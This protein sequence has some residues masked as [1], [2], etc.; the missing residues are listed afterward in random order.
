MRRLVEADTQL[1]DSVVD[2][3]IARLRGQTGCQNVF[4]SFDGQ[5]GGRS[6]DL[7]SRLGLGYLIGARS[8]QP[9][10]TIGG[11]PEFVTGEDFHGFPVFYGGA[12]LMW[13]P[14]GRR[15]G[16]RLDVRENIVAGRQVTEKRFFSQA[17][18]S[19]WLSF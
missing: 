19:V 1:S 14:E 11:G 3:R 17:G 12:G 4:C 5:F 2:Q 10:V 16:A 8:F 13:S 7:G 6:L 9:F 18:A 15:F